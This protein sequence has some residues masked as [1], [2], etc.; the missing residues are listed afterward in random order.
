MYKTFLRVIKMLENVDYFLVKY[1]FI[2]TNSYA[3]IKP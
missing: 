1:N 3:Q 2:I